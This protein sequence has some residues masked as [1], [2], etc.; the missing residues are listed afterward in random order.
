ME[1]F[2]RVL[3]GDKKKLGSIHTGLREDRGVDIPP[4]DLK[5]IDMYSNSESV[6]Q[7]KEMFSWLKV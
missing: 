1:I 5:A 6:F 4:S 7:L 3:M 2:L